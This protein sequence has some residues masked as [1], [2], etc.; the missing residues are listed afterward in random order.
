[1]FIRLFWG[2]ESCAFFLKV[3]A[4]LQWMEMLS[5]D[6]VDGRER[7]GQWGLLTSCGSGIWMIEGA[8]TM[9]SVIDRK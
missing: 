8:L 1:M 2:S 3:T 7:D 5:V 6:G 4:V 9:E